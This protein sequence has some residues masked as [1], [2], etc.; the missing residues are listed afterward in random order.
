MSNESR[1]LLGL[2]D[3]VVSDSAYT[4]GSK[5][6]GAGYHRNND[7]VHTVAYQVNAF[8]GTIKIQGTLAEDPGEYDWVDVIEWGG[9]S[10]YYSANDSADYIGTQTFTGKFI[11]LRVGHNVQDGRIIQVLYNY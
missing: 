6:K 9:D 1:Q 7:G 10:A 5:S 4:Y 3:S 8:T 2:I 11:W